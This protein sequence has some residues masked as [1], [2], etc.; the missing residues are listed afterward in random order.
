MCSENPLCCYVF[1]PFTGRFLCSPRNGLKGSNGSTQAK[2]AENDAN[3]A[4][5]ETLFMVP[6]IV[7]GGI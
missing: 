1:L 7:G 2:R 4:M 6:G 3:R 5:R